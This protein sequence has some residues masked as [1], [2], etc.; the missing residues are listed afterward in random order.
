VTLPTEEGRVRAED[1]PDI[2]IAF[3]ERR[4]RSHLLL[5]DSEC[6]IVLGET[7]AVRALLPDVA[8]GSDG[9]AQLSPE[10]RE[11][12]M[13]RIASIGSHDSAILAFGNVVL[14]LVPLTGPLGTFTAI[15]IEGTR[16]REDLASQK[17]A[18]RLTPREVDVLKL[19]LQG[20][21]ASEVARA[22]NITKNTAND[23]FKSLLRK[24]ESR[25]RSEMISKVLGWRR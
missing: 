14:R 6:K 18:Y 16:R 21:R 11:L 15:T 5:L 17:K 12:V 25:N 9:R 24:T 1:A 4:S 3:L 8:F 2:E 19:I 22:L 7:E 23:Y 13:E 10:L 20:L